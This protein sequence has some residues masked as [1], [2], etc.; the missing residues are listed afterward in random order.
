MGG[1][2]SGPPPDYSLTDGEA[3]L[4]TMQERGISLSS[5]LRAHGMGKA[6]WYRLCDVHPA[7]A[8]RYA[9]IRPDVADAYAERSLRAVQRAWDTVLDPSVD[10]KR[11]NAVASAGR[12]LSDRLAWI[13]GRIDPE[14]WGDAVRHTGTIAHQHAVVVLPPLAP[15]TP[16]ALDQAVSAQALAPQRVSATA[17][18]SAPAPDRAVSDDDAP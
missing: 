14:R 6:A 3:V 18:L 12:N 1:I 5:A 15:L 17:R 8:E 2:G 16:P 10:A 4:Q 11:T 9:A 13:A 7:L